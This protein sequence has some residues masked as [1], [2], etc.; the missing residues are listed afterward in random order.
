MSV[1]EVYGS[2]NALSEKDKKDRIMALLFIAQT[3]GLT[4]KGV[5]CSPPRKEE[6]FCPHCVYSK[7]GNTQPMECE[8]EDCKDRRKYKILNAIAEYCKKLV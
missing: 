5:H 8:E 7:N 6:Y 3:Y 1:L 4:I 2:L